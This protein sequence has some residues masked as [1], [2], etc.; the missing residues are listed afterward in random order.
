[1]SIQ[2]EKAVRP[3]HFAGRG[4]IVR[5]ENAPDATFLIALHCKDTVAQLEEYLP[6]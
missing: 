3:M 2:A 1:M 4:Q 5:V 6:V